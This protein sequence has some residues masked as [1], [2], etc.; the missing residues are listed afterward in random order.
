MPLDEPGVYSRCVTRLQRALIIS[1]LPTV[2]ALASAGETSEPRSEVVPQPGSVRFQGGY[3]RL[4]EHT[5]IVAVGSAA[6]RIAGIFNE[7]LRVQHG[8]QLPIGM[9]PGSGQTYIR[10]GRNPGRMLP[11]EGYRLAIDAQGVRVDGEG[12]GLFYGMQTLLQLLP[13]G[14]Q[15]ILEVPAVKITDYPRFHYRGLLLDVG[16]HFF[17]VSA[18]KRYLDLAA[19]YKINTFHWHLTDDQGWRIEIKH[20]PKLTAYVAAGSE[21]SPGFYTQAQIREIV[22]YARERYITVI[23]EI[24]MPGHAGAALET[25]P[26]LACTPGTHENVFC[27][28][29]ASFIFLQNVLREVIALFPGSYIHIGGDEVAKEG[30]H[31]SAEAQAIMKRHGLKNEEELQS[32]FVRR[33]ERFLTSRGKRTMGWDEIL[34]GGLAP[35]AIVMSWRGESGG[36]AAVRQRHFAVMTPSE[37]CYF[38]YNQGDP[39]REPANIGGFI[40]L[41]KAYRYEPIPPQL[42]SAERK[43]ILGVQ[44]NV[45]TEYIA[46]P[47]YLD[48]MLFPRLLAFAEVAWSSPASRNYAQFRKRLPYQL[49]RLDAQQVRYRIPEPEGLADFYTTS[50]EQVLIDLHAALP[51]SRIY[52]TLDGSEPFEHSARY[53]APIPLQLPRGEPQRLKLI[54]E[55]P[56]GRRSVVYGATFLRRPYRDALSVAAAAP[57]LGFTVYDGNFSS[58]ASVSSGTQVSSGYTGSLELQQFARL[59]NYGVRFSGYLKIP[60]DGFYR[61][62][63]ESDD[64]AL[65]RI[66][67]EVVVD[68][69]GN[70]ASRELIGHI[71]LRQGYHRLQLDYFQAAGGATLQVTWARQQAAL[72]PLEQSVLFH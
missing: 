8:M 23:P 6:R 27:P 50:D 37:Y 46:T 4:D 69:D 2:A 5:R 1:L 60:A 7:A 35:N 33:I 21:A 31:Q 36:V 32:Y 15:A 22:A 17:P 67:D 11:P 34:E 64:G 70:H 65:L 59:Q 63:V 29:E 62:A 12:A 55:T 57:G 53:Q 49:A 61:F 44:A 39:R 3:F 14:R 30:W 38:D 56:N 45:W 68:N 26:E 66:D 54:V 40:P 58:V 28:R 43:F 19:Q 51:D 48:Y 10:F 41:D 16:R 72:E 13:A 52:Y 24:E 71:P 20:Y 18:V 9:A 42:S 47:E 25:Y